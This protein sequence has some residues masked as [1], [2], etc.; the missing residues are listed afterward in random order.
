MIFFDILDITYLIVIVISFFGVI[1]NCFILYIYLKN[2]DINQIKLYKIFLLIMCLLISVGNIISFFLVY[3]LK[4]ESFLC[5]LIGT[6]KFPLEI[7]IDAIQ[8][9]LLVITYYSLEYQT[10]LIN[11]PTSFKLLVLAFCWILPILTG[12]FECIDSFDRFPN[13]RRNIFCMKIT[14]NYFSILFFSLL[15]YLIFFIVFLRKLNKSINSI[16]IEE[17]ERKVKY[18]K[19]LNKYYYGFAFSFPT[20][21]SLILLAILDFIISIFPGV[22]VGYTIN[23][24]F[25][26]ILLIVNGLSPFVIILIYC[27]DWKKLCCCKKEI[28]E[29][30]NPTTSMI[31]FSSEDN[32]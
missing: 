3:S 26:M 25:E 1:I 18:K 27:Y 17:N 20:S 30:E 11:N 19:N 31:L 10:F 9:S 15:F 16:E 21:F 5:K 6:L 7:G 14:I 24:I 28:E 4:K 32:E 23:F 22:R 8:V 2:G 29:E 13:I 12:I